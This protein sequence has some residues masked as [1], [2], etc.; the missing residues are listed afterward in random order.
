MLL[1]RSIAVRSYERGVRSF[2]LPEIPESLRDQLRDA[3]T[4]GIPDSVENMTIEEQRVKYSEIQAGDKN[5]DLS[6][7][8]DWDRSSLTANVG[9]DPDFS[10]KVEDFAQTLA[11]GLSCGFGGGSC[12]SFP[13]NWAPL[14][15]G[16]APTLMGMP[17]SRLTTSTGKPLYSGLTGKNIKTT[18][19]CFQVPTTYPLST[20]RFSGFCN[21]T[22]GAGGML[23]DT[24][25]TNFFRMYW[26]PT[27]TL[28]MGTAICMG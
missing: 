20:N 24:S 17:L 26:T 10:A 5:I 4:N 28:G 9:F 22:P 1:W 12:M 11:D 14:A 25:P 23:G 27:L 7:R 16:S 8:V 13:L 19:G 18:H 15:P 6:P 21:T 3:D 2:S